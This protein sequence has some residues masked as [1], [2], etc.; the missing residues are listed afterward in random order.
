[1]T[2]TEAFDQICPMY[3]LYGMTYE[4][5]WYGDPWM[6]KAYKDAHI[7]KRRMR[8]EE[9]WIS[10]AYEYNAVGA[11]IS[12]SFGKKPV[13]YVQKPFDIFEKTAFEKKHERQE[14]IKNVIEYLKTWI[15]PQKK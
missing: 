2:Y 11:V 6:V 8:N 1:M 9:L 15:T 3:I 4:Q 5:F 10:G 13:K 14:K 7:L 12:S